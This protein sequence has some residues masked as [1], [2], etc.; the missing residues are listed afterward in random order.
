MSARALA[1][2]CLSVSVGRAASQS[3]Y[4]GIYNTSFVQWS[5]LTDKKQKAAAVCGYNEEAWNGPGAFDLCNRCFEDLSGKFQKAVLAVGTDADC[6]NSQFADTTYFGGLSCKMPESGSLSPRCVPRSGIYNSTFV[7]WLNLSALQRDGARVC[8][9]N[10]LLWDGP[11]QCRACWDDLTDGEI[12]A[13]KTIG[14]DRECWNS[15]FLQVSCSTLKARLPNATDR[16]AYYDGLLPSLGQKYKLHKSQ[17]SHHVRR[18]LSPALMFAFLSLASVVA[19][20]SLIQVRK[21]TRNSADKEA[22]SVAP[23]LEPAGYMRVLLT[24]S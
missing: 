10:K 3:C 21:N 12:E 8:G 5:D 14:T 19:L 4:D 20:V 9:Y 6:W 23:I 1:A 2:L 7:A 22:T 15:A 13:L 24:E 16:K 17:R 11:K 18:H